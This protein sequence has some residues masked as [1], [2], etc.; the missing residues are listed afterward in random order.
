MIVGKEGE[1]LTGQSSPVFTCAANSA[2][3]STVQQWNTENW[4]A[5]GHEISGEAL[6]SVKKETFGEILSCSQWDEESSR[7]IQLGREGLFP[8]VRGKE[9]EST[10]LGG[11]RVSS[12]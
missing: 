8:L 9:K 2:A 12:Y 10:A 5:W 7:L 1:K 3:P 4:K 11:R 6:I